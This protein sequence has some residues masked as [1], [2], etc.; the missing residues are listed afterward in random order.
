M[1]N[2]KTAYTMHRISNFFYAMMLF[3]PLITVPIFAYKF[4]NWWLL[5]GILITFVG[6]ALTSNK[7]LHYIF[8]ISTIGIIVNW[9]TN[10]FIFKE[11]ITFFYFCL[12]F[13]FLCAAMGEGYRDE[14]RKIVDNISDKIDK[15][16]KEQ[17]PDL[18]D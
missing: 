4:N 7:K 12:L 17:F 13:G 9:I 18:E 3:V 10:H 11:P 2:A 16:L 6:S 5:F 14:E 8:Y 15:K 1:D